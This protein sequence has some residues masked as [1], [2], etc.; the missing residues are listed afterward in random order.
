MNNLKNMLSKSS[1][2]IGTT[3][4][5][6]T[7]YDEAFKH[8]SIDDFFADVMKAANTKASENYA[9]INSMNWKTDVNTF[10]SGASFALKWFSDKIQASE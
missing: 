6:N 5:Q 10:R 2:S 7:Q 1:P 4:P 8:L 3:N 9:D